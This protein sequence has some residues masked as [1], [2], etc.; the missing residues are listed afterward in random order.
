MSDATVPVVV[1]GPES[2]A[3]VI[4]IAERVRALGAEALVLDPCHF[5]SSMRLTLGEQNDDVAIDGKRVRPAAVYVRN[6]GANPFRTGLAL[7]DDWQSDWQ[8]ALLVNRERSD[9]VTALLSRWERAGIPMYNG[10][11]CNHRMTKPFQLALLER[12]GLPV[13][14]TRWTNDPAEVQSFAE[15]R[16]VAYKPVSGGAATRELIADDLAASR[17]SRLANAPVTF[18]ELLPGED[19]R[20]YVL[21]GQIAASIRI[22]SSALDFRGNEERCEPMELPTEVRQQCVRAADVIHL[23]FTGL[24][25]KRGADGRLR[26]LELNCS[27]MFLGF[28]AR[29]GTDIAGCLAM[30]LARWAGI[31]T[32]QWREHALG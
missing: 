26:F 10:L 4:G 22:V 9:V 6:M 28:D 25:L 21:D 3:H 32:A 11:V 12:A 23:R 14:I 16:R 8:R 2:D 30:R 7:A 31:P 1:V 20:V 17:L 18:Q 13:P 15:G 19:I 5:P 24:D 27:P 29:A